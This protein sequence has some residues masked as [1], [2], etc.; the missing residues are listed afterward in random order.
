MIN[1]VGHAT[2]TSDVHRWSRKC[3]TITFYNFFKKDVSNYEITRKFPV[4]PITF[5]SVSALGAR[6][7]NL[8]KSSP[9][10]CQ[11]TLYTT[12]G[13]SYFGIYPNDP[14]QNLGSWANGNLKYILSVFEKSQK[15]WKYFL[16]ERTRRRLNIMEIRVFLNVNNLI[17]LSKEVLIKIQFFQ[18]F[19]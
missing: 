17:L 4:P 3:A 11:C 12:R 9:P 5:S 2:S 8:I 19:T 10:D 15:L 1:S 13:L 7:R 16:I 6:L 14:M 18:F